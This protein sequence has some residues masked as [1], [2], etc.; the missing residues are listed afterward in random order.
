MHPRDTLPGYST[1]ARKR[2][3]VLHV[4]RSTNYMQS[5]VVRLHVWKG[6]CVSQARWYRSY[7]PPLFPSPVIGRSTWSDHWCVPNG[8]VYV[9]PVRIRRPPL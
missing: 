3:L 1:T 9:Q 8:L 4:A 6:T 5:Y 7:H 2:A